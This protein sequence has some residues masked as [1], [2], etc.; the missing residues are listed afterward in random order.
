[1]EIKPTANNNIINLDDQVQSLTEDQKK[2]IEDIQSK[3]DIRNTQGILSYGVAAQSN[4]TSFADSALDSIKSKEA[5]YVGDMLTNLMLKVKD[6][7]VDS[8]GSDSGFLSRIPLFNNLVNNAKKFMAKYERLTVEIDKIVDELDK[9]QVNLM[10]DIKMFDTLYDKN[11]VYIKNLEFLI[12]AGELKLK[13][14]REKEL[15]NLKEKAETTNDPMDSQEYN[16]MQQRVVRFERKLDDLKRTKM[17]AVQNAPQIRLIQ[18][19]DEA[20]T[21]KIQS[22]I[23]NTIPLWKNQI[24]IAMGLMRQKKALEIQKN[25]TDTTNKILTK[26]SEMLKQGT[27]EIQ[28]ENERGIV[29]IETLKKVN[30][31]LIST[32]EETIKIQEDGR[33]KRIQAE[34]DMVAMEQEL[35]AKLLS[36]K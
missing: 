36:F 30:A 9:A 26:N 5:G 20:L 2:Q 13:E 4:L 31:D 11:I 32:I 28:K 27:I 7:D 1:M 6:V 17:I 33:N 18:G 29:E 8:I 3:I 35:K 10:R 25:V 23:V 16:D 24:V 14:V 15:P 12:L 34:K 21:E 19:S 22:S